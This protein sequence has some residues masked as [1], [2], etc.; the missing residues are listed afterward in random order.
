[1][2]TRRWR[3]PRDGRSWEVTVSRV[4]RLGADRRS[5]D[6]SSPAAASRP[7][8]GAGASPDHATVAFDLLTT[9]KRGF[10]T[11][12]CERSERLV[13]RMEDQEMALCLEAARRGGRVWV[14]PRSGELWW[15]Q[16]Y[17][18]G[19]R[20]GGAASGELPVVFQSVRSAVGARCDGVPVTRLSDTELTALL[21]AGES[22]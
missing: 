18:R 10:A 11:S 14:D 17:G 20:S 1:M 6:A 22:L 21:D 9:P 4:T 13:P 19:R 12:C 3:D 8:S 5:P 7:A 16:G 2:T 15:V